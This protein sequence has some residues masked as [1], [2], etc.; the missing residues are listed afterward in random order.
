MIK[1]SVYG[2]LGQDP[3]IRTGQS[4]KDFTTCSVAV[5]ATRP[6]KDQ[7]TVWLNVSAFG[8]AGQELSRLLKGELCAL[9]GTVHK[10]RYYRKND[11]AEVEQLSLTA[12]AVVSARSV[13][14]G[15]KRKPTDDNAASTPQQTEQEAYAPAPAEERD[16]DDQIP[17]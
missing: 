15:A 17:F 9:T 6:G 8:R 7:E 13:C 11:G 10:T 2:R 3:T 14:P 1:A 16:L 4:G 5:D 12:E